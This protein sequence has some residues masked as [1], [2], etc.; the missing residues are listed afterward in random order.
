MD[1]MD[2]NIHPTLHW[3]CDYLAML[4]LKL[5]CVNEWDPGWPIYRFTDWVLIALGN[6]FSLV[7]AKQL[8]A[9]ILTYGPLTLMTNFNEI[10]IW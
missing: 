1:R 7:G 5:I 4:G 2:G 3:A 8:P 9:S 6:D 10:K